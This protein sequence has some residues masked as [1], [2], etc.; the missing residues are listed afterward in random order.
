MRCGKC[1]LV[2]FCVLWCAATGGF[3]A[4]PSTKPV[5][6]E[7]QKIEALIN[8][9]DHLSDATFIRNGR[10]YDCHAAAKHMRDKWNYGK[11]EIKTAE[12]FI[13]KAASKSSI[14]GQPLQNPLQGRPRSR[15]RRVPSPGAD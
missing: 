1:M 9:I 11:K 15:E 12:D 6:S 10:E 2:G 4:E 8:T 13:E 3:A 5:L 7:D 14:S